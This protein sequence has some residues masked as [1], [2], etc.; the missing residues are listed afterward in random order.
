MYFY[1]FFKL[2]LDGSL[3]MSGKGSFVLNLVGV[4]KQ[5]LLDFGYMSAKYLS[6]TTLA[7]TTSLKTNVSFGL[8][9]IKIIITKC[10]LSCCSGLF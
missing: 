8:C 5:L 7:G 2:L 6:S 1:Q 10:C 9:R 4:L 3:I